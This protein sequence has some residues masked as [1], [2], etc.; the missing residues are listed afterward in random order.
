MRNTALRPWTWQLASWVSGCQAAALAVLGAGLLLPGQLQ[1][2][3]TVTTLGGGNIN[4]PYYGYTD[5]DTLTTAEF[6]MPRGMALD[7]SGTI[8]FIADY[9]NNAIRMV[10]PVGN[11][12]GSSTANSL[13]TTFA[14]ATNNGG[15]AGIN[16]PLAVA[17]D[18]ATNVYVLNQGA[19]TNGAVLHLGGVALNSGLVEVY[20]PL[21]S[22]LVNATAM[23]MD[24]FDNLYVTVNS[25][26]VIRVTTNGVVTPLG[27]ISP[28]GT[29]LQGIA[30]L[31]NGQLALSDAGNHGIWL[32]NPITGQSTHFTGFHGAADVLGPHPRPRSNLRPR[33]RRRAGVCWW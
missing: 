3:A 20:P 28:A 7:P 4:P 8:L 1:A 13:T 31:D 29:S 14:N 22:G 10:T 19:G 33:S 23:T 9:A 17:V 11:A 30:M 6:N 12:T 5:G 18:A 27:T 2:Q 25:N 24:G 15:I 21:T 26:Q 32:L 16:H